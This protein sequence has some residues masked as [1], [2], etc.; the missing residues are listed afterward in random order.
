[1]DDL[2]FF[3][4]R[5]FTSP[6]ITAD[7][8]PPPKVNDRRDGLFRYE[9]DFVA[10]E[11]PSGHIRI[12]AVGGSTTVNKRP[13]RITRKA[14][15]ELL[16]DS[17]RAKFPD[18][19]I[20]VYNAGAPDFSSAH[21]LVNI[22][23]RISEF[24]PDII[25]LMHNVND[26]SAS[27]FGTVLHSDYANKYLVETKLSHD[28]LASYSVYGF[29]MQSRLL[30]KLLLNK[31]ALARANIH[32]DVD[33]STGKRLFKRNLRNISDVCTRHGIK[34]VFLTQPRSSESKMVFP[35]EY[36]DEFNQVI[37]S[38]AAE[39]NRDLIDMA[40][41]MGHDPQLFLDEVHYTPTGLYEFSNA[42]SSNLAPLVAEMIVKKK[43]E[44]PGSN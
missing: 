19:A 4:E 24:D 35:A 41:L 25:L 39:E 40:E 14:Y 7:Q 8:W 2:T 12:I 27:F 22:Q 20:E 32:Y 31:L 29:F 17:L 3:R 30:S 33:I 16:E 43:T 11:N 13:Y 42:L 23:F 10:K 28:L 1:V 26:L 18:Q 44:G 15:P 5:S 36:F 38:T 9:T 21:S 37:V 34:L 6:F